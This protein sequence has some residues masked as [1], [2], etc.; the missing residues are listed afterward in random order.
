MREEYIRWVAI[1]S[2]FCYR[3]IV[4]LV[5]VSL[6]WLPSYSTTFHRFCTAIGPRVVFDC[7]F[8]NAVGN[9]ISVVCMSSLPPSCAFLHRC[10]NCFH[11]IVVCII[12][13]ISYHA[14]LRFVCIFHNNQFIDA[15]A[16]FDIH[17]NCFHC[18]LHYHFRSSFDVTLTPVSACYYH[19]FGFTLP[20]F[21]GFWIAISAHFVYFY[22]DCDILSRFLSLLLQSLTPSVSFVCL[23][24]Y[25]H[26]RRE[27]SLHRCLHCFRRCIV[28]N[29]IVGMLS[30]C[31][32]CAVTFSFICTTV[33]PRMFH[34]MLSPICRFKSTHCRVV[35]CVA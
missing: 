29:V 2:I 18:Y 30:L 15:L 28:S 3:Y 10:P 21:T 27:R 13:A 22:P 6:S 12:A 17:H 20:R 5:V 31:V 16:S 33:N 24:C 1:Y 11:H 26:R 25:Y 4:T 14:L 7:R 19:G 32:L 23:H 34:F 35:S 8:L 9:T